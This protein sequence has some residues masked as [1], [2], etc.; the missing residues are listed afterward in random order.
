[1]KHETNK[2]RIGPLR[3]LPFWG[4]AIWLAACSVLPTA[5]ATPSPT[6]IPPTPTPTPTPT[7]SSDPL[8]V[9]LTLWV[10]DSLDP[11]GE[12][13]GAVLLAG[14]L[15]EFHQAHGE[16]QVAVIVKKAKGRGGLLDFLRTASAVAPTVLPDLIVLDVDDLRVAAQAGLLQPLDGLLPDDL[17]T[18]RFP[19]AVGMG[20]VDGQTMGMP[21]TAELVH[22]AYRPT[23]VDRP[24]LTWTAVFSM[25]APLILPA[26][27]QVNDVTLA[28]YL[29]AGGHL[30]DAAGTPLLEVE[31][32]S[33]VLNFYAQ[34]AARG[35]ISPAVTLSLVDDDACWTLF[36]QGGIG[37]TTV[38]SRQFWSATDSAFA[39]AVIPSRDGRA[40]S[41]VQSGWVLAL[42]TTDPQRQ[43]Q[44]IQ[45]LAWLLDPVHYAAWTQTAGYLPTTRSGLAAWQVADADW[46]V[47]EQVLEG[48][49]PPLPSTV[50]AAVGPP[51]QVALESVLHGR[52]PLDAAQTAVRA[53]SP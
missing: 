17:V 9:T 3:V 34:A 29:G 18:D 4:L 23:L 53:V 24:P 14:Q 12:G 1:M 45:L 50:R 19:F 15:D 30:S 27:A 40:V 26:A 46:T 28:Q 31:P 13:A 25:A 11:Y 42:V 35:V 44:A 38:D 48:A 36:Q 52:A 51:L 39:P 8:V 16:I 7:P 10:P 5:T 41:L 33:A 6:A 37:M 20:E 22:M 43:Q 47:L 32:L 2:G 49:Q 21:L